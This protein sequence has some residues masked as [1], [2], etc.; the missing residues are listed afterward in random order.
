MLG[1]FLYAAPEAMMRAQEAGP[2]ADVYGLGMTALFMVHGA[3]LPP[4]VLWETEGF[5]ANLDVSE[6][7]KRVLLRAVARKTQER[8]SSIREFCSALRTAVVRKEADT[9]QAR[10]PAQPNRKPYTQ[11]FS[12]VVDC[13]A[14]SDRPRWAIIEPSFYETRLAGLDDDL[15]V[16]PIFHIEEYAAPFSLD[17]ELRGAV[18][19]A[20]YPDPCFHRIPEA[21]QPVSFVWI[22]RRH[23]R[24]YWNG[25]EPV[26]QDWGRFIYRFYVIEEKE[27]TWPKPIYIAFTYLPPASKPELLR[28]LTPRPPEE[29]PRAAEIASLGSCASTS[30][31][32]VR[33]IRFS[34]SFS[35]TAK[36]WPCPTGSTS[37]P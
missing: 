19:S 27:P 13:L 20:Q 36:A 32:R 11:E 7:C 30:T 29:P 31:C 37:S 23:V 2:P 12:I 5:I 26:M 4:D 22:D 16:A 8:W 6:G 34:A 33:V 9:L 10:M 18:F 3:D 25:M 21:L 1:T 17:L 28:H 15:T 14:G 35:A 24:V